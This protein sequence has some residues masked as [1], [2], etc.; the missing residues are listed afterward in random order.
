L[1]VNEKEGGSMEISVSVNGGNSE[2]TVLG[3][4]KTISDGLM[5]KEKINHT[6][7]HD[8][9]RAIR[10]NIKDSFIITSSVIGFL[11]KAIKIDK[12]DLTVCVGSIELYSM[13]DDMNLLDSMNVRKVSYA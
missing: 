6:F 4:I 13:L 1:S 9:Q 3:T 7:T 11:V 12:M 2:I 5:I 8:K 10:L